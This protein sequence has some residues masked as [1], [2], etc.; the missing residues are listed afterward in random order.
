MQYSY[1]VTLALIINMPFM[2]SKFSFKSFFP[3]LCIPALVLG[4]TF[5][6]IFIFDK[7]NTSPPLLCI[8]LVILLTFTL[9]WLLLGEFRTKMIKVEP[10][11]DYLTVRKFGRF[12]SSKTFL[13]A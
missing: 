12:S 9:G 3:I 10:T 11:D 1:I 2:I 13:Y 7:T 5:Y 8:P 6:M 4:L